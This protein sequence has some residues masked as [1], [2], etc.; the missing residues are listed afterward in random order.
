[1][2]A[3]SRRLPTKRLLYGTAA[4]VLALGGPARAEIAGSPQ[5]VDGR[6]LVMAGQ[7]IRLFGID[8]PDLDQ[9]C[10]HGGRDYQ[11]GKVARAT[12]WDL[13]AGLDV[14]CTPEAEAAGPDGS[15]A[16]TCTAGDRN[17]NESMVHA[18]WALADRAATDRYVATEAD[19]RKARR[20]LWR[21]EFEPPWQW[22]QAH[23]SGEVEDGPG[24]GTR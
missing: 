3:T 11:C 20:G 17:L 19:A 15:I 23:A 21:G 18:G 8:A 13:V 9:V 22:R 14:S 10:Q 6:T 1:M 24:G 12:L 5:I 2:T 4:I 16:A 7:Q